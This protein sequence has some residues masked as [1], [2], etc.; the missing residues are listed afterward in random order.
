VVAITQTAPPTWGCASYLALALTAAAT[1]AGAWCGVVGV[2]AFGIAAASG[3]GADL[4]RF[5][6]LDEPGDR[7]ADAVAILVGA[8][9][10]VLW[11]PPPRVG[12]D[13]D[14]RI[15]AR[16]RPG[17]RQRGA[18][19]I[20]L[21]GWHNADL[22]LTA[23][24]AQWHGLYQGTGHLTGRLVT[25]NA[26]GRAAAGLEVSTRIWLPDGT[27]AIREPSEVEKPAAEPS[28]PQQPG[29]RH[30]HTA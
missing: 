3:L 16:L 10:L 24:D 1:A 29:R 25:V 13:Y 12:S 11:H 21:G 22:T 27:G 19:L 23:V 4:G 30:L 6:V 20:A 7:W 17:G 5:L 2:P 8:C 26:A 9:D 28:T 18:A 15:R 14:R